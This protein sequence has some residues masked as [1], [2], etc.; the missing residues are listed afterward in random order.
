MAVVT[1]KWNGT[2]DD[3]PMRRRNLHV[4]SDWAQRAYNGEDKNRN[5][6][7]D[8]DE[9]LDEDGE[10][11]RYILPEPPPV[12][13]MAVD[14]DDQV[15]TVYWQGNAENFIDPISREMDFEGYRIYGARKTVND[16]NE[17][18]TLLGEFDLALA[19]HMGIGYN[20]GFEFIRIINDFGDQD[21]VEIDGNVYHYKF[22]NNHVKNGW[23]NYYAVTAY[24]RGDPD[25]NLASLES[26]VY[27]NRQYVYPGVKPDA[28][29]WEGNPSVYPN[30]YKGQARW[31]GYGS[32]AQMIWFSNLPRKAEIRIFTLAG[33]LVD[34][35][36]H[37]QEYQ[38]SDVYNIDEY[39]TPQLSGGEHAWDLI[40]RDD[41]AIAS[42]LYLFTVKNLDNKS[43]SYGKV[44][45]G[46]FLIIK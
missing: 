13:N 28:A 43:L 37:D 21:S 17:E 42:G 20:T 22:V 18:F 44:K 16:S 4:N 36:D 25:A 3:S 23:L 26:S 24:D 29:N 27:A 41:Q 33:D 38:G 7:L 1:A 2:D 12:P 46:K 30:P 8:D 15:V 6:I 45:E 10:I 9:D 11:D 32:R 31:D 40:T 14:V 19:E 5:N 39:K 35:L 34:I